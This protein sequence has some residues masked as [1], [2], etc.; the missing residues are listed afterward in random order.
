MLAGV[1]LAA[2]WSWAGDLVDRSLD[3]H[4][5]VTPSPAADAPGAEGVPP[6]AAL[7]VFRD[8]DRVGGSLPGWLHQVFDVSR[9]AQLASPNGPIRGAGVY[10]AV[11]HDAIACLIVRLDANGMVWNCTSVE[12]LVSSGM[13]LRSAI[14]AAL[15][16][17]RDQ[18]GD[19]IAGAADRSD[20]L[21]VDWNPDGTFE[22]ERT[23]GG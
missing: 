22:I 6:G 9:V 21:V 17:G 2:G 11:S 20:L 12:R 3:V 14:P 18:D 16:T 4:L 13:T 7:D 8:P 5:A 23:Q 1:G 10:A 19:G 15:D